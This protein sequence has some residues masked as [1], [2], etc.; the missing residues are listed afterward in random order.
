MFSYIWNRNQGFEPEPEPEQVPLIEAV[1]VEE[2]F[3]EGEV[4]NQ[5]EYIP[6]S[7]YR[8][9]RIQIDNLNEICEKNYENFRRHIRFKDNIIEELED[10]ITTFKDGKNYVPY[11]LY[12][13]LRDE[14]ERLRKITGEGPYLMVGGGYR[15]RNTRRK[16]RKRN[17]RRK[18]RKK[19]TRRKSKKRKTRR[20]TKKK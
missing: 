13:K 2:N 16:S 15:R 9:L 6:F 18:S 5:R 3:V 8:K 19:N 1:P 11:N 20:K 10:R 4:F 7:V 12:K 17:T 14:I